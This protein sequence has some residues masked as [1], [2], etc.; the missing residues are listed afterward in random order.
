MHG[1]APDIAGKG[2]AN[3]IGQIWSGAMMLDYLGE[4]EAATNIIKAIEKS[5]SNENSRTRDL[6]G[7][8]NTKECTQSILDN[9]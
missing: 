5:L 2:I 1:S 4:K 3:P 8:S 7:K 9:L 6:N